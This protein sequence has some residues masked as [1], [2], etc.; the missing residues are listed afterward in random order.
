[1][2]TAILRGKELAGTVF[3]TSV[4]VDA[5]RN[6]DT[7]FFSQRWLGAANGGSSTPVW[8]SAVV[9]EE[10]YAGAGDT[11]AIKFFKKLEADFEKLDRILVP[12]KNDWITTGRVLNKIGHKYGFEQ[13]G[14]SR[15]TND[16]LI[17][18]SVA[19][20]GL[21]IVTNNTKDFERIAEFRKFDWAVI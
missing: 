6:G 21:S 4:Y 19:R 13:I 16:A 11:T 14:K 7:Q 10:L 9:L 12:I 1:M 18:M 5:A 8:L 15:L 17:A 3:D 20:T 2:F